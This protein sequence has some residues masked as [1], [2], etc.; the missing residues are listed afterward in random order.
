[1]SELTANLRQND[2]AVSDEP[3]RTAKAITKVS[4]R[5]RMATWSRW[6]L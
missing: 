3:G 1:V 4:S 5:I 6:P 2:A